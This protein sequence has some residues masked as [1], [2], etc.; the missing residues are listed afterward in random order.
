MCPAPLIL[1][2]LAVLQAFWVDHPWWL[3]LSYDDVLALG[4][5]DLTWPNLGLLPIELDHVHVCW[6]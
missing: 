6:E 5:L 1:L 3:F 4:P 2:T